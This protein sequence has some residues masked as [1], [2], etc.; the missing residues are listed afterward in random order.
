M[1]LLDSVTLYCPHTFSNSCSQVNHLSLSLSLSV[2]LSLSLRTLRALTHKRIEAA[3]IQRSLSGRQAA[4]MITNLLMPPSQNQHEPNHQ[5]HSSQSSRQTSSGSGSP[6]QHSQPDATSKHHG[7]GG[8]ADSGIPDL[9]FQLKNRDIYGS[10]SA[11]TKPPLSAVDTQQKILEDQTL[12]SA[13]QVRKTYV[14]VLRKS[15]SCTQCVIL[16]NSN[17]NCSLVPDNCECATFR[18]ILLWYFTTIVSI[19]PLRQIDVLA[20]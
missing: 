2:S 14:R 9:L 18:G 6:R 1:L 12:K 19:E 11:R 5:Y 8:T 4:S 20:K 13:R 15:I 10:A 17:S 16:K 3:A 7:S